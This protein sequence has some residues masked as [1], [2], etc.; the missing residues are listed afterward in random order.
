MSTRFSYSHEN[1]IS[2]AYTLYVRVIYANTD[3]FIKSVSFAYIMVFTRTHTRTHS[4]CDWLIK[5][6]EY[7]KVSE[8]LLLSCVE[9]ATGNQIT[10]KHFCYLHKCS[11]LVD[12]SYGNVCCIYSLLFSS[13]KYCVEL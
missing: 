13:F 7:V 8:C 11:S 6:C 12:I 10:K 4:H 3:P 1:F 2:T 9:E 5:I